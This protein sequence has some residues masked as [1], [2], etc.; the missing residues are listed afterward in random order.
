MH[1]V[2]VRNVFVAVKTGS[3]RVYEEC[4][5]ELY[6]CVKVCETYVSCVY[7]QCVLWCSL[8]G[9]L[10]CLCSVY[11]CVGGVKQSLCMC[12]VWVRTVTEVEICG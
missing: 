4:G 1:I 6:T 2:H 5:F 12:V 10:V 3:A 11:T 8:D 9:G 7:V